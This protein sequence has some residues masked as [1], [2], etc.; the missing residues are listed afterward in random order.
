[1]KEIKLNNIICVHVGDRYS[2]DYVEKLYRGIQR[3]SSQPFQFTVLNDGATYDLGFGNVR[4]I[5]VDHYSYIT[6]DRAWWYKMQAFREDVVQPGSN[7][8]IDID[9]VIVGD[10]DKFW[11]FQ[12]DCFVIIQDFNRQFNPGYG[13]SNSSVVKFTDDMAKKI[14]LRWREDPLQWVRKYRGDQDWFDGEVNDKIWWPNSWV[15]SWKWE[16]Y[17][18]GKLH[19]HKLTYKSEH[20]VLDPQCSILAF[21]GKPDPHEVDH[22]IVK[23][24]W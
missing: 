16:V 13:R 11:Q 6:A 4:V 1:L 18:G 12:P 20:T 21:H 15:R 3:H 23:Q 17:R 10:C 22:E 14:D 5:P 9:T 8:L 19:A 7:L 2:K 24:Q